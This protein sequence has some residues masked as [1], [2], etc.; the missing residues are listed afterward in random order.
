M[1]T[2][3]VYGIAFVFLSSYVIMAFCLT[4]DRA[5]DI[6]LKAMEVK[7]RTLT[8]STQ[9]VRHDC[10]KGRRNLDTGI[11]MTE[12]RDRSKIS[13]R[14]ATKAIDRCD[15]ISSIWVLPVVSGDGTGQDEAMLTPREVRKVVTSFPKLGVKVGSFKHFERISTP[16]F[17]N[18]VTQSVVNLLITFR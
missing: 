8:L 1:D 12:K 6:P 17:L 11:E 2:N 14:I 10:H 13:G 5:F 16:D 18:F 15:D 4:Y 9:M 3:F 7:R